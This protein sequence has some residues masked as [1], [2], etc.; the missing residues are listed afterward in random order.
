MRATMKSSRLLAELTATLAQSQVAAV[1]GA[2]WPPPH[3]A[4]E[5]L[6]RRE[7]PDLARLPGPPRDLDPNRAAIDQDLQVGRP[8]ARLQALIEAG[9]RLDLVARP[10]D[11]RVQGQNQNRGQNQG[12]DLGPSRLQ[13]RDRLL[14]LGLLG[15]A[16]QSQDLVV[17]GH[18]Q[19][20]PRVEIPISELTFP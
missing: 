16:V 12:P 1:K 15:V 3:L 9:L 4:Q 5:D 14:L 19:P 13:D 18:D 20:L 7:P 6:P 11:P 8:L 2:D 17:G 10:H